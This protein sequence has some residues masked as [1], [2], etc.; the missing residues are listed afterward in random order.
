MTE[1]KKMTDRE[2]AARMV[3]YIERVQKLMDDVSL[4]LKKMPGR[5]ASYKVDLIRDEYKR[6]KQKIKDDAHY[7]GLGRNERNDPGAGLYNGFFDPSIREASAF[8]FMAP[9]NSRIDYKFYDALEEARYKL[10]KYYSL[11]EW[12]NIAEEKTV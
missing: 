10:T 8:G 6:L 4:M 1:L 3:G 11:D 5:E 9:T 12:K 2:L 7:L